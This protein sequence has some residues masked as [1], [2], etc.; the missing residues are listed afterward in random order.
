[1]ERRERGIKPQEISI[2]QTIRRKCYRRVNL[3]ET[4]LKNYSVNQ[5]VYQII[6]IET[7]IHEILPIPTREFTKD[8]LSAVIKR[9]SNW[10]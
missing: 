5:Q 6:V 8:E 1:M 7:I 10:T 4:F 3:A 9:K 2:Q